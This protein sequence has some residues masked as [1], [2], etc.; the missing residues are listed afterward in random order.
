MEYNRMDQWVGYGNE[1]EKSLSETVQVGFIDT[2]EDYGNMIQ[3]MFEVVV[4][5][6]C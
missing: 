1:S 4:R 3:T 5:L 2:I 6:M